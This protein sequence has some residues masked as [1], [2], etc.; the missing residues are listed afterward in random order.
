MKNS[1]KVL[2]VTCIGLFNAIK[3][4][5]SLEPVLQCR[6]L[7]LSCHSQPGLKS[8]FQKNNILFL[9]LM[10][11][12]GLLF[13]LAGCSSPK[14][15]M[16]EYTLGLHVKAKKAQKTPY[17]EKTLKVDQAY[18]NTLFQSLKMYYV[19]G[20]YQQY[21]YAQSQW[22]QSPSAKITQ[23]MTEYLRQM[24][25]FKSVQSFH[26][27]S[28]TDMRLEINIEDFMHYF[29][30]NE[31]NSHVHVRITCNLIDEATHKAVATKTFD[32]NVQAKSN[33][34]F[35]GVAALNDAMS[36]ILKEC[37]LW[38]QEMNAIKLSSSLEPVLQ[39]RLL[40]HSY[41]FM[42]LRRSMS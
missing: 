8:G 7:Q 22:T 40:Q 30:A 16:N 2:Y 14:P 21:A 35:G 11:L 38:L 9:N 31:E 12:T 13:L 20:A 15:A 24:Q 28:E 25:L 32:V 1:L 37:G 42:T 17:S 4:S 23:S 41:H 26:S 39:C 34:A 36:E 6:L 19:E 29:D 18:G 27:K 33:D 3:L 5:S 10:A